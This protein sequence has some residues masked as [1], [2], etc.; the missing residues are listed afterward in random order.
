MKRTL[1]TAV[2]VLALSLTLAAPAFA[3]QTGD[4]G[5]GHLSFTVTVSPQY[6]AAG[7]FDDNGLAPVRLAGKWGYIDVQGGTVIPFSYD[8]A[9]VF[10]EGLA[11]V[12]TASED[13]GL[14]RMGFV[15]ATLST[16]PPVGRCCSRWTPTATGTS[17]PSSSTEAIS[18][19]APGSAPPSTAPTAR[20]SP[21]RLA[22][23]PAAGRSLRESPSSTTVGT[24]VFT[25]T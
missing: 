5:R 16:P 9:C 8:R 24:H 2:L 15:D 21:C 14:F 13:T 7:Q 10:H 1:L 19:W 22:I 18:V 23:S 25:M 12:A 11:V 20:R 4:D 3:Q 17:V 6:E